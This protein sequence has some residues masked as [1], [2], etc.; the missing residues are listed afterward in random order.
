MDE[1]HSPF[2]TVA[3]FA[4]CGH[5]MANS[6]AKMI[7]KDAAEARSAE[8]NGL[9]KPGML[10]V[11]W[12]ALSLSI[13]WG[14]RGNFGHEYGAMIPGMLATL[15]AVLLSGRSDWH[16]RGVFFA[17]FGA[18]GWSFGGSISYMQVIA[19]THSGHSGSQLYGF[20]CLFVIG[21]LWA[22]MGGAGAALPAFLNRERLTE[23]FAPLTA[24]FVGWTLQDFIVDR[25]FDVD[26]AF[27]QQSILYWYDTDWVAALVA[28]VAVLVLAGVRR[29]FDS[30]ASLI[31]HMAV[32]WWVAFL[33][34]VNLFGLRMT[35]PRG[36]NW[37]GCVGMV[38][39]M[40]VYLWRN[41]LHGVIAATLVTGFIGGFGF[42]TA[43][44]LKLVG[45]AGSET[46]R[47]Q[48]G[49]EGIW[50]TNWHSILEQ[51]YG[52]INGLGVAVA[53]FW[54]ARHAPKTN[55]EPPVR[56][57]ADSYAAAFVLLVVTYINLA[58]N[59]EV[60]VK[61][62][63]MPAT[64][65]GLSA[66]GW[67][68]LAYVALALVFFAL[69]AVHRRRPLP[70]LSTSWLARGQ[71]LYLAFLWVMVVGNF[72]RALTSFAPQ[73]LITE[74]VVFLNAALCT[75]GI[76]LSAPGADRKLPEAGFNWSRLLPKTF[77]VGLIAMALSVPADWVVVRAVYG[78]T[79]AS[80]A[81]KHIRFG[82]EATATTEKPKLDVPH[83]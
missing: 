36:D 27:R 7:S 32:G 44:L 51:S 29:R 82:P 18:L 16:R 72:E 80:H 74:G 49:L 14:I 56:R 5:N 46:I 42:A 68:N 64:L 20:A 57:W 60:W 79:Q 17:F 75:I 25:W 37:A 8:G 35:P 4:E 77:A 54:V 65:Y 69:L 41:N 62:K 23:F 26:P 12:V 52:F 1:S 34:L 22:A 61:A 38:A 30:A 76:F 2:D 43:T 78:D 45:M 71:M 13:G 66:G 39:G 31:L 59:P 15:A 67:F 24:V 11:L 53:L 63:A 48:F 28:I 21:F 3:S 55:E 19:Y 9:S 6:T 33:V 47:R 50:Q 73:R 40:L 81:S 70:L 10:S 58:K 83:P